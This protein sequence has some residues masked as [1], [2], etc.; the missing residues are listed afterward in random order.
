MFDR[1]TGNCQLL[2]QHSGVVLSLSSSVDGRLLATGSKDNTVRL[3]MMNPDT[4]LFDCV[5]MGTG[6]T[7]VVGAVAMSR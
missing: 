1:A 6:H 2:S 4:R 3:W 7:H 5:A